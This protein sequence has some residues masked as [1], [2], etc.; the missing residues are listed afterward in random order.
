MAQGHD[1][2]NRRVGMSATRSSGPNRAVIAGSAALAF[3]I[4]AA[5][6]PMVTLAAIAPALPDLSSDYLAF[7]WAITRFTL[8]QAGLS[9]VL[10]LALAVPLARALARQSAFAGRRLILNLLALPLALPALVVVLGII[11]VWGRQGWI[12]TMLQHTGLFKPLNIDKA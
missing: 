8:L 9:T 2:L 5:A 11:E 6:T 4:I 7:I 3:I 12:S 1:T 10:S